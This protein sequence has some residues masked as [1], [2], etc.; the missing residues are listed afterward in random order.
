MACKLPVIGSDTGGIPDIIQNEDTGL[1]VPQKD[2]IGISQAIIDLIGNDEM[3]KKL[4]LNGYIMV[5][6]YFSWEK[7]AKE[8]ISIYKTLLNEN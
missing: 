7:I 8:Y 6:E 3:R 4:A 2:I 1:I 5:R